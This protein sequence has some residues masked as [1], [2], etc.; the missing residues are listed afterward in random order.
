[1][2]KKFATRVFVKTISR[3]TQ[4]CFQQILKDTTGFA[5]IVFQTF[6]NL[7]SGGIKISPV[8]VSSRWRL[9]SWI[10][11]MGGVGGSPVNTTLVMRNIRPTVE[12]K[13]SKFTHS[14]QLYKCACTSYYVR[15]NATR[16]GALF[17]P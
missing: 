3:S 11:T 1:M 17:R 6:K 16:A 12:A 4:L 15:H 8:D 9:R 5:S 2:M 14:S 7:R 10:H 13:L